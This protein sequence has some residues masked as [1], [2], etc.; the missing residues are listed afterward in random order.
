M[1]A[2]A[3]CPLDRLWQHC[4]DL[5]RQKMVKGKPPQAGMIRHK[6]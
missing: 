6:A 3:T 2:Q 1:L 4:L 5:F